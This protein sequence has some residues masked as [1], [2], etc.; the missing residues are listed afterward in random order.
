[1]HLADAMSLCTGLRIDKMEL[2]PQFYPLGLEGAP[3]VVVVT[4]SGAEGKNYPHFRIAIDAL[5]GPLHEKGYKIVQLGRE[6]DERIGADVDKCGQTSPNQYIGVLQGATMVISGDTSALH[7]AG[8]YDRHLISLFSVSHPRNSGAYF[9]DP[10]KQ[11]YLTPPGDWRPSFNPQE[12]PKWIDKIM[13]EQIVEAAVRL[14]GLNPATFESIHIGKDFRISILESVPNVV[15]RPDYAA[16]QTLNLRFDKGGA[17][18]VV[19]EQLRHRK[20]VVITDKILNIATLNSLRE[21]LEGIIYVVTGNDEPRFVEAMHRNALPYRLVSFL[22]N[23]EIQNKKLS[24]A[25]FNLLERKDHSV[26]EG[27]SGAAKIN[28]K[29]QFRTNKR[30]LSAGHVYLSHAHVTA[31]KNLDNITQNQDTIIDTPEFWEEVEF[32]HLF[33]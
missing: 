24:Y 3:Y 21:N 17:E 19:Y 11:I 4:S 7:V 13:P 28:E 20:S 33:N 9:G 10:K 30:V 18:N 25:E 6:K 5:R 26:K 14:L 15:V 1:M 22:P 27:L 2:F 29:T 12:N 23:E 16:G 31:G 8:H 32:F